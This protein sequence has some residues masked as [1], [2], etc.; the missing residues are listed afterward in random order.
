MAQA[1]LLSRFV[2]AMFVATVACFASID[3]LNAAV[4]PTTIRVGY[5]Q[6]NG[7]QTPTDLRGKVLG[8]IA[9]GAS[10]DHAA[11]LRQYKMTQQEMKVFYFSRQEDALAA[12]PQGIVQAAV[13][14]A[15]KR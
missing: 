2:I 3:S 1:K 15:P 10:S 12:L 6:L 9:K 7:G 5:P 8:V 13:H 11:L 4:A 14:S